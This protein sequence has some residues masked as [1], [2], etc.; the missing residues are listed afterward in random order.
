MAASARRTAT[1]HGPRVT[2]ARPVPRQRRGH[3]DTDL[4]LGSL[5]QREHRPEGSCAACGGMRLTRLVMH[6]G[7]GS[8]VDFVSCHHCEHK[9]WEEQGSPLSVTDVLA[10]SARR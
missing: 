4:P 6:L 3:H 5:T 2:G 8:A 7:D 9:A 10:R 1:T